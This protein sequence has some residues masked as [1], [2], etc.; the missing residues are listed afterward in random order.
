[1]AK[2]AKADRSDPK[3][4]K[5]LAIRMVL[6]NAP[7][8]KA[9]EIAAAVQEQYGHKVTPTLIYLVKS[10]ANVKASKRARRARGQAVGASVGSAS[11]WIHAI[12]LARQ[13][14]KATGNVDNAAAILKAVDA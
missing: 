12:K 10:K 4:N 3:T 9:A 13:L 6:Q 1:M 5:S 7:R 2:K 11:E 8:A 14:L